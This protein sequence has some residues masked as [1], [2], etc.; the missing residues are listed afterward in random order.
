VS[1]FDIASGEWTIAGFA[2]FPESDGSDLCAGSGN[3]FVYV[4]GAQTQEYDTANDNWASLGVDPNEP[5]CSRKELH[6]WGNTLVAA[7]FSG[8]HVFNLA[9]RAW[10]AAPIPGPEAGLGVNRA[11]VANGTLYAVTYDSGA[12]EVR[13]WRYEL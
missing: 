6:T 3:G 7:G 2:Q 9:T 8:I 11:L 10:L 5:S 13:I 12:T 1:R 4:F